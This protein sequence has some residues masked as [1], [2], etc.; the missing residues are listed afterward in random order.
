MMESYS[1]EESA[2][3]LFPQLQFP[4]MMTAIAETDPVW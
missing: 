4:P 1:F 2:V 3:D